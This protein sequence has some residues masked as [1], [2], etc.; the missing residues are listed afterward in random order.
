MGLIQLPPKRTIVKPAPWV[1]SSPYETAMPEMWQGSFLAVPFWEGAGPP[2]DYSGALGAP[3]VFDGLPWVNTERG[4]ASLRDS[5]SDQLTWAHST[6]HAM[7]AD[8]PFFVSIMFDP[9]SFVG[10]PGLVSRRSVFGAGYWGLF[11]SNTLQVA[12]HDG[13]F[14]TINSGYVVS[15]GAPLHSLAFARRTGG[16]YEFYADGRLVG[17]GAS[18]KIPGVGTSQ[19]LNVGKVNSG[20][21]NADGTL[22]QYHAVWGNKGWAPTPEQICRFHADP[23]APFRQRERAYFPSAGGGGTVELASSLA[24]AGDLTAALSVAKP[25]AAAPSGAG[26]IAA[27]LE[28][29]KR[30]A[31]ALSGTADVGVS[32]SVAKQLATSLA[33]AAALAADLRV[34]KQLG[35]A[36]TGEGDLGGNLT[37]GQAAEL[38]A[39]LAAA[40]SLSAELAVGKP[41]AASLEGAAELAAALT[42]AKPLAATLEG[43]GYVTADL[44]ATQVIQLAA[45]LA[46]SAAISA[47]LTVAKQ[48]T[49]ALA[50]SSDLAAVLSA[51]KRL[52]A[53]LRGE[54]DL[55]AA[56][57]VGEF[58][59]LHLDVTAISPLELA[60]T[61]AAP[62]NLTVTAE[63]E[64]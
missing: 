9:S 4:P 41:L 53:V 25:L 39:A 51:E 46:A 5:A 64:E 27:Q 50:G 14:Q 8:E 13:S 42:V 28:V 11:V 33:G 26:S 40:G 54:G 57:T 60:V 49:A 21:T 12:L 45:S 61:F 44:S 59:V 55:A 31:T 10:T 34:S 15:S 22:G 56:L 16:A 38:A 47:D 43:A 36:L 20:G 37:V 24:A 63:P 35:A 6:A 48:L 17:T 29:Q 52:A 23:F 30:L 19:P 62:L 1:I 3:A 18:T 32:L 7:D 58:L 2:R